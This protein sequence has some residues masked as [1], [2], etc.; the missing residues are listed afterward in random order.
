M[1]DFIRPPRV[2]LAPAPSGFLHVGSVRTALYNWLHARRYGGRFILRI[3]DTDITRAT[4]ESMRAMIDALR[5]TGLDWD[6][7]PEVEGPY[8]PYRQ[9]E[10]APFYAAVVRRLLAAGVAYEDYASPEELTAYREAQRAAGRTPIIKGALRGAPRPGETTPPSVRVA[11]PVSGEIVVEDLV[12]GR[13]S[14][15]WAN[16]GDFVVQRADGTATYPLASTTDDVAQ[17]MT[18]VCRGEDLLSVTPRQLLLYGELTREGL[19]DEALAEAGL[20]ARESHWRS[21]EAFA[22]LPLIV[23]EDRK[24]LSKRHGSVAVEEFAAQGYLPEVL[25]NYLALLGWSPGDGRERMG[26]DELIEAFEIS[27][28]GRTPAAFDVGK[29]T[30]CNGE[31]IR[32]LDEDELTERL[33]P[34]LD[35]TYG[36]ASIS[37]PPTEAERRLLRSLVPLVRERLERL[38]EVQRQA[39]FL[40]RREIDLDPKAVDKVFGTA[41]AVKVLEAA[42]EVVAGV[43]EW[44]AESIEQ[45]L[46]ELPQRLGLGARKAFQPIRVA[47]TGS[48]VSPPLFESLAL[49]PRACVLDRLQAALPVA[50]KAAQS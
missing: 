25:L 4:K 16:I 15:D 6:E 12:R 36:E 41:D 46:R 23:A 20:P 3:E 33:V 26:L 9:S 7:G 5:W 17:G 30:A 31:R 2:R 27:A 1:S 38:D 32:E 22:H 13:V 35:G 44:T 24:P 48:N 14:F 47:V 28:V 50:E 37:S 18:L 29:L 39:A 34:Y 10:R 21:P 49:L 8:G 42:A 40:F 45:G 19:I 43:E 11:T